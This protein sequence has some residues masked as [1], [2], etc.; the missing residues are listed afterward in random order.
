MHAMRAV[1]DVC[2]GCLLW[3][4]VLCVCGFVRVA[5]CALLFVCVVPCL[6]V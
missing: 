4:R 3:C 2:V 5:C 6:C 1:F